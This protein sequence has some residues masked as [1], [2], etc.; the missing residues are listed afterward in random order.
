MLKRP[1][2]N[3]TTVAPEA[4]YKAPDVEPPKYVIKVEDFIS[5]AE[6]IVGSLKNTLGKVPIALLKVL[7]RAIKLRK[8]FSSAAGESANPDEGH[9]YFLAILEKTREILKPHSARE[10][11]DEGLNESSSETRPQEAPEQEE[12]ANIFDNLD[13][14]EP[15]QEFLDAPGTESAPPTDKEDLRPK[16]EIEAPKTKEEE[17]LAAHCLLTDVRNIRRFLSALWKDYREGMDL[18]AAS[19][20][21]NTAIDFV[22]ELELD[23][24]RRF[25]AKT[26]YLSIIEI[27]YL[28]QSLHRGHNPEHKQQQG[29][30]FNLAVYDLAEDIMMPTWSV[31]SSLQ[32][33]IRN[34]SVPQYKSGFLGHRDRRTHWHQKS[35]RDKIQDD[36]LVMMEAFSDLY[37]LSKMTSKMPL[38]E[39]ELMRGIGQMSPGK[40]IPLWLVFAAQCFLDAQ[41]ELEAD[42]SKG[43][44]Q[45]R[46]NANAIRAS[47]EQNLKFHEKLRIVNWPK[48]NDR[49]FTDML[50]VIDQWIGKDVVADQ[51][52]KIHRPAAIPA[53]EPFQL[54]RQYPVICG[55]FSFA[56]GMRY[57]EL[58]IAFINAWGSLMYTGQLY[59][60][61]CQEK[62]MAGSKIW[63]DME[64]VIMLQ[65]ANRFFVGDRPTELEDY[66]KRFMLSIGYSAALFA[67]N[68]R[69]NAPAVSA[70]GPRH[71]TK[72]CTIGQL[73]AERYCNNGAAVAWTMETMKPIIEAKF[74]GGSEDEEEEEE[75]EVEKGSPFS[76]GNDDGKARKVRRTSKQGQESK[77]PKSKKVKQSKSGVLLRKATRAG[78]VIPTTDF[79]HDLAGG[80]HAE[81]VEMSLDHLR[82]HRFCW[83]LLRSIHEKCKPPTFG[84]VW[85]W[86]LGERESNCRS[87][88]ATFS[89]RRRRLRTSPEC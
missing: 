87:L 53:G 73:F 40:D 71:L 26:D 52:Q 51:W 38:A 9:A 35:A 3:G 63:K 42:V 81:A 68:R 33:V 47:I 34:G 27:Y 72:L 59:N 89:C 13:L 57:Q 5:L 49:A 17:Y 85:R 61:V 65:R 70:K 45:L 54:L 56:L 11:A 50:Y 25:P 10:V 39:D 78:S 69:K 82:I 62:L 1:Q 16:Y 20:T 75:V 77:T 48:E 32:D 28:A 83:M 8:Q 74:D 19:I 79:L 4:S 18:C 86:V 41:H 76:K 58:Q 80:L 22:R 2:K 55:L 66:L 44:E 23:I 84:N 46:N 31:L 14:E 64:F 15:S 7:D 43:H 36:R 6:Y 37:I 29:D 88:W 30:L 12:I 21:V 67:K 60:A 24:V